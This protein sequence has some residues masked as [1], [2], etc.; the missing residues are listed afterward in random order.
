MTAYMY[1]TFLGYKRGLVGKMPRSKK[2]QELTKKEIIV[3]HKRGDGYKT[4]SKNL[5]MHISTVR[6]VVYRW[7]SFKT[8]LKKQHKLARLKFA[9]AHID[10]PLDFWR[11]ILW[12]DE[13]K[14]E[15]FSHN[16][17]R[18]V[19]C[20]AYTA[21]KGKH[22]VPTV[23]HGGSIMV[24]GCFASSGTGRLAHINGVMNSKAYQ[25]ILSENT[26]PSVRSL[27]LRSAWI[28]QQDND[29]RSIPANKLRPGSRRRSTMFWN[30][31]ARA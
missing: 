6:Q 3:A 22:L 16:E 8:P 5:G 17:R 31:L 19:W 11:K 18:Y 24:W 29:I 10:K 15:I 1:I 2:L 14:I 28:M 13:S 21:F 30:C 7:R 4:I 23:R 9:K 26:A 20:K 25:K 27:R 12:T